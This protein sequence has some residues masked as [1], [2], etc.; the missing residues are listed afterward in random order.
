[1]RKQS[2]YRVKWEVDH[3]IAIEL[4]LSIHYA[5]RGVDYV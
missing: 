2:G 3:S 5:R 1:M 4:Y